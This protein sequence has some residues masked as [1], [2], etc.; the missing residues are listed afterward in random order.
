MQFAD[1]GSSDSL[2]WSIV[3]GFRWDLFRGGALRRNIE[4][5]EAR[6][7]QALLLYQQTILLALEEVQD[8]LVG[9]DRE[10]LRRD[11]LVEAVDASQR[12][13]EL[14]RTQYL[15]G[16]TNFQ[17]LLDTQRSLFQQQDALAASEGQ[18]VQN[19]VLLNR[20]LGGG[21]SPEAD[22]VPPAEPEPPAM[23]EARE[24]PGDT[25]EEDGE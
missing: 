6:T 9:L 25:P 17:N 1:L 21:W 10:R 3:P 11:R 4:V 7:E 5:Q 18:V 16:L 22:V 15:S 23:D 2:A 8:A 14:V 20:A 13:V 24:D 12:A 19:L